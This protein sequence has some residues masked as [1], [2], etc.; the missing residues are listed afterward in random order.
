MSA[1]VKAF[2]ARDGTQIKRCSVVFEDPD[3][4]GADDA[5]RRL[6]AAFGN[7]L[8]APRQSEVRIAGTGARVSMVW[9]VG[10]GTEA[11]AFMY[12]PHSGGRSV[13]GL[14]LDFPLLTI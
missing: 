9:S 5:M 4:P 12:V 6:L 7:S 2:T 11:G 14:M 8:S 3:L 10:S 1:K 13:G